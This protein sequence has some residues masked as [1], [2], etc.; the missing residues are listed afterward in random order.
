MWKRDWVVH[1]Q[2]AGSGRQVLDYL[3]RYVF[4]IAIANSRLEQIGHGHVTFRY[5]ESRGQ[6]LR[7]VTLSALE[8]IG[9]FLR[10]VL[11]PGC[12]TVRYYGIWSNS[13]RRLLEQARALLDPP[14]AAPLRSRRCP[15][16][17]A[18]ACNPAGSAGPRPLS[19]LPDRAVARHSSAA[20]AKK[21]SPMTTDWRFAPSRSAHL[22][23]LCGRRVP[24]VVSLVSPVSVPPG[25][26]TALLSLR[27]TPSGC[28]RL[29]PGLGQQFKPGSFDCPS[30]PKPR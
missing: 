25:W 23:A 13:S 11:P 27:S 26:L 8:L 12:V 29:S 21:I 1:C 4:R 24:G 2:P 18:P 5:R 9:R 3:A 30:A 15:R 22:G 28:S 17:A 6:K 14:P 19:P 10:H 16:L 7:R 20:S